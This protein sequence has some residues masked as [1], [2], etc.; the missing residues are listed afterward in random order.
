[1][2]RLGTRIYG[3]AI[4]DRVSLAIMTDLLESIDPGDLKYDLYFA[5]TV[6]EEIGIA[7]ASS[8]RADVDADL[9]IALDNG[10]VG[11]IPTV[12]ERDMPTVLGGG[13][14]LVHK[15]HYIHDDVN[16]IWQLAD[17]A[18]ARGIPVQH[19]VYQQFGSDGAALIRQGIPAALLAPATRYTHSAFEM[20]D[21][22]D[23]AHTLALLTAFVTAG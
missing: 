13:P 22:R 16:L 18:E 2:R 20:I 14:T 12:S 15:D 19:A 10:I 3:K 4:D 9:A 23:V 5:A 17:L 8:L 1:V 7:G 21:E 11:D 6:Q